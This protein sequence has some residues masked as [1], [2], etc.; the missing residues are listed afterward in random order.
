MD[1][2]QTLTSNN[3]LISAST[4]AATFQLT[5]EADIQATKIIIDNQAAT[6]CFVTTGKS[7]VT[8]VF[9]TAGTTAPAP[10]KGKIVAGNQVQVYQ[11][12]SGDSYVSIILTSGT[13]NV[14]VSFGHGE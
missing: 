2:L 3:Y 1:V 13:G 11:K 6:A 5:D 7:T 4:S 12:N 14:S 9:P 8:A 10:L